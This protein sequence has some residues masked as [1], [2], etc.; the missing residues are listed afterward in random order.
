MRLARL[1]R[2]SLAMAAVAAIFCAYDA[3]RSAGQSLVAYLAAFGFASSTVLGG[4][5]LVM[6]AHATGARWLVVLRRLAETTAL[7]LP[8]VAALFL[9][10]IAGANAVFPW[11]RSLAEVDE[12]T[13]HGIEHAGSWLSRGSF[14]LRG[15]ACLAAW[16]L[17]AELIRRASLREDRAPQPRAD[18]LQKKLSAAGLPLVAFSGTLAAFDWFMS[19]LPGFS[20]TILGLYMLTG[21]FGAAVGVLCVALFFARKHRRLPEEVGEA[22]AHALG[23]VLL[24]SVCLW[25]YL[26]ASQLIIVWSANL[27]REAGFYLLRYH[28]IF[29]WLALCLIFGHFALPFL[30][31]L[32]R[33]AKRRPKL[34]AWVGGWLV[35]MHAVD[36][37][38][39]LA[40]ASR[41]APSAADIAP[42][43]LVSAALLGFGLMRFRRAPAFAGHAAELSLSLRY[44]ST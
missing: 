21:G 19:A 39:L 38:W 27:P 22:H 12:A 18:A 11:A 2:A 44:E 29:R 10:L 25:A 13:R 20:S 37:Y 33:S 8:L 41:R 31:L 30:I 34:L 43:V 4:L 16:T 9:P 28:G 36:A 40:A 35:L 17:L 23:R 3:W 7:T 32:S 26:A 15:L 24:M 1:L 5:V 42:F 6:V 14:A